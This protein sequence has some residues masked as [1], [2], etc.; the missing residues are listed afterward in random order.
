MRRILLST[1]AATLGASVGFSKNLTDGEWTYKLNESDEA[2]LTSYSGTGGDVV[3]PASVGGHTVKTV[4]AGWPAVFGNGN[5]T[6]T[7]VTVPDGVTNIGACAFYQCTGLTNVTI[8][9]SVT[10][11]GDDA[12]SK[13]G[14][15]TSVTIGKGVTSI[16]DN[17]FWYSEVTSATIPRRL[18][19]DVE[20]LF[21]DAKKVTFTD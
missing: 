7:S 2:T 18:S 20:R 17:V 9:D 1:L 5:T 3:I 15:L 8:P 21:P 4:G 10:S 16:G 14:R 19:S 12:F 13:C 11:I 6:V